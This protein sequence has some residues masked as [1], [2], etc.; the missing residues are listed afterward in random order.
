MATSKETPP[1]ALNILLWIA[2]VIL[3]TLFI[4]AG[5][6][7]TTLPIDQLSLSVP[8]AKDV[9]ETLVRFIGTCELLGGIGLLLPGVFRIKPRLTP[10]AASGL[11][12]I[13]VFATVFHISRGE[14]GVIGFNLMLGLVAAFIAW[15]R[16]KKVPVLSRSTNDPPASH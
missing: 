3:A 16:F 11:L 5:F 7:K 1:R 9:P 10:Y 14:Y 6:M 15:G 13:Q 8:W 2:Q 12:T 4:M